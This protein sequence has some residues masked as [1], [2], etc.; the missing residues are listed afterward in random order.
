MSLHLVTKLCFVTHPGAPGLRF[1]P[2]GLP[3]RR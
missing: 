2:S 1:E 3:S